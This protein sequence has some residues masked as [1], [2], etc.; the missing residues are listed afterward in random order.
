LGIIGAIAALVGVVGFLLSW[1]PILGIGLGDGL[2]VLAIVF[3]AV[4]LFR[5]RGKGLAVLGIGL[6]VATLFLKSV[7]ILRWF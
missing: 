1:I 4:G 2:G 7:P 6:G 5:P 3:G